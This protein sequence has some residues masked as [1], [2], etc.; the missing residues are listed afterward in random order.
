M[1]T[2]KIA[3]KIRKGVTAFEGSMA[4][5]CDDDRCRNQHDEDWAF[6]THAWAYLKPNGSLDTAENVEALGRP[7]G[8]CGPV[9][10]ALDYVEMFPEYVHELIVLNLKTGAWC[11]GTEFRG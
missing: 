9:E 10:D 7:W 8:N 2:A 3:E 11:L 4:C 6:A 1:L 5:Q